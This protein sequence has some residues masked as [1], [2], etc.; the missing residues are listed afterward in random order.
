MWLDWVTNGEKRVQNV[1]EICI[2]IRESGEVAEIEI[3]M[4]IIRQIKVN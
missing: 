3:L 1:T 4:R 2:I